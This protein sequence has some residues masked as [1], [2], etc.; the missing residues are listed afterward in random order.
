MRRKIVAAVLGL[1]L[2]TQTAVHPARANWDSYVD[3]GIEVLISLIEKAEN[4]FDALELL[5]LTQ[6][7]RAALQGVKEDLYAHVDELAVADIKAQVRYTINNV[8]MLD[9]G[10]LRGTYINN[11]AI[12][13]SNAREKLAVFSADGHRD[14]IARAMIAE[15]QTLLIGQAKVGMPQAYAEYKEALAHAIANMQPRCTE[16]IDPKLGSTHYNCTW[17]GKTVGGTQ[18]IGRGGSGTEVSYDGVNWTPGTID[19]GYVETKVMEQTAQELA[20]RALFELI[21]GGH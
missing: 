8:G 11:V 14:T 3:M 1:V 7:L 19:H 16:F 10:Q 9:V 6:E 21:N 20:R 2:A 4:G 18:R 15:Y 17:D 13:A 12:A 5:K